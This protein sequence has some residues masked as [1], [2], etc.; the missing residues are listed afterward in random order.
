MR[1]GDEFQSLGSQAAL[2]S[3]LQVRAQLDFARV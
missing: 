3:N 2:D 1:G